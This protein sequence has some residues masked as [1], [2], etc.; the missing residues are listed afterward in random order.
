MA[1]KKQH[2]PTLAAFGAAVRDVSD[3]HHMRRSDSRFFGHTTGEELIRALSGSGDPDTTARVLK[4]YDAMR[5][6]LPPTAT[7][8]FAPC[9]AGGRVDVGAYLANDPECFW[10]RTEDSTSAGPV[11]ISVDMSR[12]SGTDPQTI[13]LQGAAIAAAAIAASNQRPVT[14]R[15]VWLVNSD[16]TPHT[17]HIA[18]DLEMRSADVGAV[19]LMVANPAAFRRGFLSVGTKL[20]GLGKDDH[21]SFPLIHERH[22]E[23]QIARDYPGVYIPGLTHQDNGKT[24]EEWIRIA[25]DVMNKA[26]AYE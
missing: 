17:V 10:T 12:S 18:V 4:H 8:M 16:E 22:R 11:T 24:Q 21:E 14:L 5:D 25:R 9:V 13:E 6:A 26:L 20:I 3:F 15:F 1:E 23:Q 2:F 19:A 7:P